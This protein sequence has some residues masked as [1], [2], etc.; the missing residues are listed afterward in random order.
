M[1][2]CTLDGDLLAVVQR[3]EAR[4]FSNDSGG[5]AVYSARLSLLLASV[6]RTE[7]S[8]LKLEFF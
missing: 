4:I 2:V 7:L 6:R 8:M 1:L 5:R 3:L